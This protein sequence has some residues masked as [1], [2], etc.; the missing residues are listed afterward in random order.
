MPV[1]A[2]EDWLSMPIVKTSQDPIT[3]WMGMHAAG[4]AL[5]PMALDFLSIPGKFYYIFY[6]NL[7][8]ELS[9]Y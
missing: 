2:L 9:L 4:N 7:Y 6:V 1:D 3:Y 8:A 5:A